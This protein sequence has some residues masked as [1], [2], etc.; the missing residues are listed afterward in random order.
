MRPAGEQPEAL[1]EIVRR[2]APVG[3]DGNGPQ[4]ARWP[5]GSRRAAGRC[6]RPPRICTALK[7]RSGRARRARSRNNLIAS[8]PSSA[9]TST[10]SSCAGTDSDG[11]RHVTSPDSPSGSRLVARTTRFGQASRN[12]SITAAASATRCS[13]LSNT[14]SV[15]APAN[16]SLA[17]SIAGR[18]PSSFAPIAASSVEPI[19]SGSRN[20]ARSTHHTPPGNPSS[21][22]APTRTASLVLPTPP[23]PVSVTSRSRPSS[24]R[25]AASS[26][27]RPI[28]GVVSVGRLWRYVSSVRNADVHD[29]EIRGGPATTAAPGEPR[30]SG[31]ELP[32]STSA[33]PSGNASAGDR[34][35]ARRHQDLPT[36][37]RIANPRRADDRSPHVVAQHRA[38]PPRRCA[39]RCGPAS[40]HHPATPRAA[41][42][43]ACPAPP[44][45]R[46]SPART[47]PP[48]CRPHP[49]RPAAPQTTRRSR[50][51][52]SRRAGPSQPDAVAMPPSNPPHPSAGTSPSQSAATP[53]HPPCRRAATRSVN[54]RFL[55]Q[56][57]ASTTPVDHSISDLARRPSIP[58]LEVPRSV[59]SGERPPCNPS[60]IRWR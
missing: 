30:P 17:I 55:S 4:Q 10:T 51:P 6:R 58:L 56:D 37:G 35:C 59:T 5:T 57:T 19:A 39:P 22:F 3:A 45:S 26:A 49:A 2:S 13:Q 20:G 41:A 44:R 7:R 33:A 14:I 54:L 52:R 42:R 43:A 11:T 29:H 50:R 12:D 18:E 16:R 1:A 47:R 38:A 21:R 24:S 25:T 46:R 48:R 40:P 32:T 8:N 53:P 28:N 36:V 60:A 31:G 9:S 15:G 34:R 27:T 23:D